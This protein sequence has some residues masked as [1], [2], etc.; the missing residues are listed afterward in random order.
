M[1]DIKLDKL[2]DKGGAGGVDE[3]KLK[4]S[5]IVKSNS[6]CKGVLAMFAHFTNLYSPAGGR[7][8]SGYKV[9]DFEQCTVQQL[10]AAACTAPDESESLSRLICLYTC[11]TFFF[12]Y[13]T[14]FSSLSLVIMFSHSFSLYLVADLPIYH[15]LHSA[16]LLTTSW[17][18]S[19]LNNPFPYLPCPA[20]LCPAPL[21][22][23]P[24]FPSST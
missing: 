20:P 11:R 6:Y 8:D 5:E 18:Y 4:K 23:A 16:S 21:C 22:P 17:P 13:H 19:D 1:L 10:S 9:V 24:P 15:S 2:R 12:T 3:S 14:L 7:L